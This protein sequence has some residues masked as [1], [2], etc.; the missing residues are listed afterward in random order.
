MAPSRF[1]MSTCGIF[2]LPASTLQQHENLLRALLPL[3][4]EGGAKR[5]EPLP[6]HRSVARRHPLFSRLYAPNRGLAD[7]KVTSN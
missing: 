6:R 2:D 7:H 4:E 1:A 3:D 5:E